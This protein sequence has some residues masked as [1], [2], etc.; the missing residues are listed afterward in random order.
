[1]HC[2]ITSSMR[3]SYAE[4]LKDFSGK[5]LAD[6]RRDFILTRALSPTRPSVISRDISQVAIDEGW[7]APNSLY[8]SPEAVAAN[9]IVL[10]AAA[11]DWRTRHG[12]I[13]AATHEQFKDRR[14]NS[15]RNR[16]I[17]GVPLREVLEQFLVPLRVPDPKDSAKHTAMLLA[18]GEALKRHPDQLCDVFLISELKAD[19]QHRSLQGGRINQ[20]FS[21]KSPDTNVFADLNYVGD[22]AL[23]SQDRPTLH[24]RTFNLNPFPGATPATSN[25]V[26]WYAMHFPAAFVKDAVVEDRA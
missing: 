11:Q 12:D 2:A 5:P 1:M 13:D 20:V 25:D 7:T 9:R 17:E 21:G 8:R 22:R 6:W 18:L 24:L 16:L 19:T 4:R 14:V 23:H 10:T 26:P 3:S 15:P